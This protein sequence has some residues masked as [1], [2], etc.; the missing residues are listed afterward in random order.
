MYNQVRFSILAYK[1]HFKV[2][3]WGQKSKSVENRWRK[4][5]P[6]ISNHCAEKLNFKGLFFPLFFCDW[7]NFSIIRTAN[8]VTRLNKQPPVVSLIFIFLIFLSFLS[9]LPNKHWLS[10]FRVSLLFWIKDC[11]L[12]DF[13]YHHGK[14]IKKSLWKCIHF[15]KHGVELLK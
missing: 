15:W 7:H 4:Q 2:L 5:N 6:I 9:A 11:N 13:L 3:P 12:E 8:K 1:L 14:V 10:Y